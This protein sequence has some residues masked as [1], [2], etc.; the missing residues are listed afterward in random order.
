[1]LARN[2]ATYHGMMTLLDAG[3]GRILGRLEQLGLAEETLVVFTSDHGHFYG[4]HGLTAKG[5][6]HYEDLVRV[7]FIVRWPGRVPAGRRSGALQSLVDLA[8]TF[9]AAAGI[10][11]PDRMS[12]LDQT[13]AWSGEG[14]PVR[15]H[16]L[17]ENRHQPTTLQAHTYIDHRHKLTVYRGAVYGELFDLQDDPGEIRNLWDEPGALGLKTDLLLKLATAEMAKEPRFMPR[18]AGA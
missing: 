5:P 10:E 7:P 17:V 14:R 8:P 15:D 1:M 2:I 11:I 18:I 12:G 3:V 9:L 4:Q 13:G 16:V 6:F